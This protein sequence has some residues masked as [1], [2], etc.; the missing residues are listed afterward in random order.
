MNDTADLHPVAKALAVVGAVLSGL[1]GLWFTIQAFADS[2][3]GGLVWLIF[4]D[5]I[6][7]T[8]GYWLTMIIVVPIALI[9]GRIKS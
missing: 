9:L 3:G 6:I 4:I 2:V 1:V 7:M 8:V 5:P